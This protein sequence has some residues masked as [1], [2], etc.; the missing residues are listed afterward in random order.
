MF[1]PLYPQ[2]TNQTTKILSNKIFLCYDRETQQKKEVNFGRVFLFL[3]RFCLL[4]WTGIT[5]NDSFRFFGKYRIGCIYTILYLYFNGDLSIG[6]LENLINFVR[7]QAGH[8]KQTFKSN[9]ASITLQIPYSTTFLRLGKGTDNNR[10]NETNT[11][12]STTPCL[13]MTH[14][15]VFYRNQFR[16]K[17]GEQASGEAQNDKLFW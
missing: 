7:C 15:K 3:C 1:R 17:Q 12:I 6:W 9:T 5:V 14:L 13:S 11:F 2:S 4:G 16:F 8:S 10:I